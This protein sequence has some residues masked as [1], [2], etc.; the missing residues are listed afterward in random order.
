MP[1]DL[2]RLARLAALH[3][4]HCPEALP[5]APVIREWAQQSWNQKAGRVTRMLSA[6]RQARAELLRS[7]PAAMLPDIDRHPL[8]EERGL[9]SLDD[10]VERLAAAGYE[11]PVAAIP[12]AEVI[13]LLAPE[14]HRA[15]MAYVRS[16]GTSTGRQFL[17]QTFGA[18]SRFLAALV[19]S[20]HGDLA[21]AHPA[22]LLLKQVE[23]GEVLELQN[24]AE[25][26]WELEIAGLEGI[27]LDQGP[28][29]TPTGIRV[30]RPLIQVLASAM[31]SDSVENSSLTI[32]R[33]SGLDGPDHWTATVMA[34]AQRVADIGCHAA[35]A[36]RIVRAHPALLHESE[37]TV[38][39]F[40]S[41]MKKHNATVSF[42]DR[43]AKSKL[44]ALIT[45]PQILCLGLP[46]LR[47]HVLARRASW[48]KAL[49]RYDDPVHPRVQEQEATYDR[50]LFR[51]LAFAVFVAD[52]LRLANYS[53]AR[54]GP[55]GRDRLVARTADDGTLVQSY[56]HV[57]PK[58][59]TAGCLIGVRTN[60]YGDDH[61]SVK[62]KIPKV[63]GSDEWR[64]REHWLRPGVVDMEL[65]HDYLVRARPKQLV[66]AGLLGHVSDYSLPQDIVEW[67]FA[68]FVSPAASEDPYRSVTGG[69]TPQAMSGTVGRMLHWMATE[70]LGRDL[71]PYGA[72]LKRL[73]PRVIS[74]HSTR[75]LLGT[76]LHGVLGRT[77]DAATLLN[78]NPRVVERRYSVVEASMMHR[79]GWEH[80]RFFDDYFTRIWDRNEVIDWEREDPLGSVP[81][82][83]RPAP[84]RRGRRVRH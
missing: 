14:W 84:L 71:P 75:L 66:S 33:A 16:R 78:D 8:T 72:E 37:M 27:S 55:M 3:K 60:F 18:S 22:T 26:G 42:G 48:K 15:M 51:Y 11:G 77:S 70:V 65:L 59:D 38:R 30:K 7:C 20:G 6:Y 40:I 5:P 29:L 79:F 62:L 21:T 53:G 76:H 69:Y 13:E 43:K 73:Y 44:L 9:R 45:L 1:S 32:T 12:V 50:W 4:V 82:E 54:L 47:A 68:L 49:L 80:P 10:I 19:R 61:A 67:H 23:T 2:A 52:G 83:E 24:E 74:G 46:A 56:T 17:K 28:S 58:L 81:L 64:E 31:A 41:G 57:E 63:A 36:S 35:S 39:A 34:D 25:S